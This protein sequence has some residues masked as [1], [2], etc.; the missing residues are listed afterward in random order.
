M[1]NKLDN[2]RPTRQKYA[3]M[4]K[5]V[6]RLVGLAASLALL[7]GCALVPQKVTI[8][9][10]LQVPAS[11]LGNGT[12]VALKVLDSRRTLRIGYRGLDSK[13]AEI[14]TEQDLASVFQAKITEGLTQ[15]G[16]KVVSLSQEPARLLKVEIRTL[17]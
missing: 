5:R 4:I 10:R 8:T 6:V 7:A 9:P 15:Q 16:F 3:A 11:H 1:Q 14:T 17:E 2:T 13:L 12:T